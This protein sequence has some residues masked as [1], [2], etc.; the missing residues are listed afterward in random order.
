MRKHTKKATQ[1][2]SKRWV[3]DVLNEENEGCC[4]V[5]E[6][7][8]GPENFVFWIIH[9]TST[10]GGVGKHELAALKQLC[11]PWFCLK[12]SAV[13]VL[14]EMKSLVKMVQPIVE[15]IS[16]ITV[17]LESHFISFFS[18]FSFLFHLQLGSFAHQKRANITWSRSRCSTR[19]SEKICWNVFH[20][21]ISGITHEHR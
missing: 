14:L 18:H 12:H 13:S 11:S 3:W 6:K 7:Q 10:V 21:R 19:I 4:Y 9:Y 17:W 20:I 1:K 15:L 2:S 8:L 5:L 16:I